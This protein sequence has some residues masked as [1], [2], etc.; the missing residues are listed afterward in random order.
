MK[1]LFAFLLIALLLCSLACGTNGTPNDAGAEVTRTNPAEPDAQAASPE[2]Q[3]PETAQVSETA[4]PEA[5]D[6]ETPEIPE[7]DPVAELRTELIE[8]FDVMEH[9]EVGAS[10]TTLCSH[11]LDG[12]GTE[13]EIGVEI[14][15]EEDTLTVIDGERSITLESSSMVYY[16]YLCDLDANSPYH[17][18]IVCADWGSD[19]FIT[20]ALHPEGDRLIIDR[21]VDGY[22]SWDD[23]AFWVDELTGIFGTNSGVRPYSGDAFEP[24]S[25]WLVCAVPSAEYVAENR[26]NLYEGGVLLHLVR[27]LPCTVDG[28][29]AVITKGNCLLL[30][31]FNDSH[32]QAMVCTEDRSVQA[33][34]DIDFNEEEWLYLIDGVEQDEYFDNLFYAD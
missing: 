18:L 5:Q 32:T 30:L 2:A 24:E 23:E 1:K 4:Q 20:T 9:M 31:R 8:V 14:D 10:G 28:Q 15:M 22:V 29:P 25:E 33:I 12:D 11:D 34:V 19:S 13:E 21:Q 6:T 27:D 17:N 16:I 26:Q 3:Q 7:S